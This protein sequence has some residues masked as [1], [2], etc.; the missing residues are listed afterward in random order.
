VEVRVIR[1]AVALIPFLSLLAG[2]GPGQ[3]GDDCKEDDDCDTEAGLICDKAEGATADDKGTCEEE[4]A[5]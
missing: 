4:P 5:S 1:N 2:C 3:V